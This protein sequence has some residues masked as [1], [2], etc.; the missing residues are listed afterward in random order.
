MRLIPA[1]SVIFLALCVAGCNDPRL[2][3]IDLHVL[4]DPMTHEAYVVNYD[5][6]GSNTKL[7]RIATADELCK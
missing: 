2:S 5:H 3:A 4:C 7:H 1:L 6:Q